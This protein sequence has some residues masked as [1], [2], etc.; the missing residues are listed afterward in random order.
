MLIPVGIWC[1]CFADVFF[2]F[3]NTLDRG[4]QPLLE[5]TIPIGTKIDFVY[6]DHRALYF[7][8]I[9]F[10]ESRQLYMFAFEE[11]LRSSYVIDET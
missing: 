8:P 10:L 11:F 9:V 7:Q 5:R 1:P 3:A 4:Q 6:I 2:T